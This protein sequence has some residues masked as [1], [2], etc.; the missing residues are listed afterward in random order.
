MNRLMLTTAAAG[1]LLA[2]CSA[3]PRQPSPEPEFSAP[4]VDVR[5]SK[6]DGRESEDSAR[7]WKL[8]QPGY[9]MRPAFVPSA[10]DPCWFAQIDYII[11]SNGNVF[12]AEVVDVRPDDRFEV[13]ALRMLAMHE[14]VPAETNPDRI[15]I[16]T[17]IT[18]EMK[19]EGNHCEWE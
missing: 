4:I 9:S 11:D 7:Y 3:A 16:H 15:P 12:N 2:A 19:I 18:M 5:E 17:T 14:Y 1:A 6:D 8:K 10:H 13:D